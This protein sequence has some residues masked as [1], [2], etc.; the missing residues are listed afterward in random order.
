MIGT[1]PGVNETEQ[2]RNIGGFS[3]INRTIVNGTKGTH[4]GGNRIPTTP[5]ITKMDFEPFQPLRSH[6]TKNKVAFPTISN[7]GIQTATI[8]VRSTKVSLHL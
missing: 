2:I 1:C 8:D 4:I 5:T 6:F 3:K 7:D